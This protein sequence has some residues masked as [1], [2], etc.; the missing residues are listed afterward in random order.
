VGTVRIETVAVAVTVFCFTANQLV[1]R[2][3]R[4]DVTKFSYTDYLKV[5]ETEFGDGTE[6]ILVT[7]IMD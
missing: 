1:G 3:I 6:R 4:S 7:E 2:R 5:V